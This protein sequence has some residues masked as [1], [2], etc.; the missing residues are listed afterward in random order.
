MQCRWAWQ[1]AL[2]TDKPGFHTHIT[3]QAGKH[4]QK[5]HRT[6]NNAFQPAL[7]RVALK[8]EPTPK[9]TQPNRYP[10]QHHQT[11]VHSPTVPHYVKQNGQAHATRTP[12][13]V[14]QQA[15]PQAVLAHHDARTPAR[16]LGFIPQ[17]TSL[18]MP[19]L[20]HN[21]VQLEAQAPKSGLT[22]KGGKHTRSQAWTI[23]NSTL[24]LRS[25]TLLHYQSKH[26]THQSS[27]MLRLNTTRAQNEHD[28]QKILCRHWMQRLL[29]SSWY[30]QKQ[31]VHVHSSTQVIEKGEAFYGTHE[32]KLH[33]AT[34][35][36]QHSTHEAE[37]LQWEA[38]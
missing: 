34:L 8:K 2:C 4:D 18:G 16:I 21:L 25:D 15:H 9:T 22:L 38:Q 26:I 1:D 12:H 20:S 3:L 24:T 13:N 29:H 10:C 36:T 19:R 37:H 31:R 28:R 35:D 33:F 5:R 30:T 6:H 7:E 11:R 32:Q 27:K 23:N 14:D 17:T